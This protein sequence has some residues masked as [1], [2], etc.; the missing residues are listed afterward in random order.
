MNEPIRI[1]RD[2]PNGGRWA[3]GICHARLST[4]CVA[5]THCRDRG[6]NT[7]VSKVLYLE[8]GSCSDLDEGGKPIFI[9]SKVK[10]Y[11]E[12]F[13]QELLD[14]SSIDEEQYLEIV[15]LHKRVMGDFNK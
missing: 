9:K 7:L 14:L 8:R 5:E 1:P 15:D 13:Y 11:F 10:T 3:C 2:D 6:S 4:R 12:Y